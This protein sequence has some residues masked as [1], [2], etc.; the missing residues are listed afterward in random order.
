VAPARSVDPPPSVD[1]AE[2][3]AVAPAEI[4]DPKADTVLLGTP[5]VLGGIDAANVEREVKRYLVRYERCMRKAHKHNQ[6]GR[7]SLRVTLMVA[8]TGA[9]ASAT[10][11]RNVVDDELA[12]CVLGVLQKLRFDKSRDGGMV[13]VVY[14]MAFLPAR[15]GSDPLAQ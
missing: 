8:A 9:V 15:D 5:G 1:T 7:G 3:D 13:K 11:T 14:P 10:A 4:E 12:E 2:R 6:M